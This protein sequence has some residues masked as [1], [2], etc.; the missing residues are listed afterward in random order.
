[1]F[2][3]RL[4][5]HDL[6]SLV[7]KF[8]NRVSFGVRAEI[9]ELTTI[10]YIKGSR[11]RALYKAGLRTP[12]AIAEASIPEI[13]KTIFESASWDAQGKAY[14]NLL[15]S[16]S[17]VEKCMG[18]VGKHSTKAYSVRSGKK[19]KELCLQNSSGKSERSKVFISESWTILQLFVNVLPSLSP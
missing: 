14:L 1:M 12:Q 7:S 13:A 18:W 5:W 2:C 6:E 8:Q 3:E 16:S 10:P 19:D 17:E 15:S 9:A 11:A 4:G